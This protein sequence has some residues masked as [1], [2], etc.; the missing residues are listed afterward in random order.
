MM[1]PPPHFL[2]GSPEDTW[3]CKNRALF[4]TCPHGSALLALHC[5]FQSKSRVTLSYHHLQSRDGD[6][7]RRKGH[8]IFLSK[9]CCWWWCSYWKVYMS[10]QHENTCT[11][12]I[13]FSTNVTS[14][15]LELLQSL[16]TGSSVWATRALIPI[17]FIIGGRPTK[18]VPQL[19]SFPTPQ[20]PML[21]FHL[22][23]PGLLGPNSRPS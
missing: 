2:G 18:G 8:I 1:C 20:V 10:T 14:T 4:A 22:T 21:R 5:D 23:W 3:S 11:A 9:A 16:V 17:C 13:C 7:R 19:F 6:G 15:I 12:V